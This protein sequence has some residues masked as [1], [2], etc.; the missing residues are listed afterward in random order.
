MFSEISPLGKVPVLK[1]GDTVLFESAVIMEYLDEV[2]PPGLHPVDP[3]QKAQNRA[4]IEFAS[5]LLMSQFNM[6]VARDEAAFNTAKEELHAKL[7]TLEMQIT[8]PFFNGTG[9]ALVDASFAPLFMRI[10]MLEQWHEMGLLADLPR[11][12]TWSQALLERPSVKNSVVDEFP[13]LCRTHVIASGS[14]IA[15]TSVAD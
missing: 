3:L 15:S 1:V 12:T 9:F 5:T 11:C 6:V 7:T 13:Q 14:F 4:W 2:N 10:D 8:G